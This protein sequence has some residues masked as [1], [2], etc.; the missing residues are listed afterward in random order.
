[1]VVL[2]MSEDV[3]VKDDYVLLRQLSVLLLLNLRCM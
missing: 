2:E 1:M 3:T